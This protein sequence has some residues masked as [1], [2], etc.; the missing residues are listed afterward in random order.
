MAGI[1]HV[2]TRFVHYSE[3]HEIV[4]KGPI[5]NRQTFNVEMV[6]TILARPIAPTLR[7][8]SVSRLGGRERPIMTVCS[9]GLSPGGAFGLVQ[10]LE[11]IELKTRFTYALTGGKEFGQGAVLVG[12][13]VMVLDFVLRFSRRGS[14]A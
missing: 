6:I 14:T 8:G 7:A 10:F 2:L 12:L 4:G 1:I 5:S 9:K 3:N 13:S 11:R